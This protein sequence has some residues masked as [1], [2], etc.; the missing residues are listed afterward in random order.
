MTIRISRHMG[1][2]ALLPMLDPLNREWFTRGVI[3]IQRCSDCQ[4]LQHPPDEHC[5]E[6][7]GSE[8]GWRECEGGGRVESVV[9]VHQAVHPAFEEAVPYAVVVVS[10]DD[11]PGINAIGNVVNRDPQDIAIGQRVRAVFE[12]VEAADG[13]ERMLIP[14]WEV[15]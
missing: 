11:A 10:L 2:A 12:A 9:V 8:L 3:T 1:E 6:C 5:G 14:Q 13:R 7:Q 15:V 4:A